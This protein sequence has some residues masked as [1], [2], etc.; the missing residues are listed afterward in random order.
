MEVDHRVGR[1]LTKLDEL[2]IADNTLV[3]FSSDNG[4]WLRL[5]NVNTAE[6]AV[7][8]AYPLKDGKFTTWEGGVRVP[9][10]VRWPGHIPAGG[11]VNQVGGLVDLLP[12]LGGI[13]GGRVTAS[14]VELSPDELNVR[15]GE[16]ASI[17]VRLSANPGG[18]VAGG[19]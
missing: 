14:E 15:E 17:Q 2:G 13:G 6:R 18:S 4:P 3:I 10:V 1:V 12:T 19:G 5:W 11:S 9:F 7:G 16:T 8:S